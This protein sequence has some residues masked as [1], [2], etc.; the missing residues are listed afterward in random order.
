M[1]DGSLITAVLSL[2]S[3]FILFINNSCKRRWFITLHSQS[4]TAKVEVR[5]KSQDSLIWKLQ[6]RNV[7][8]WNWWSGEERRRRRRFGSHFTF[9]VSLWGEVWSFRGDQA[10]VQ[11][12]GGD[13]GGDGR[14]GGRGQQRHLCL[15]DI[16]R[17]LRLWLRL[18]LL[19][20]T[21]GPGVP[22]ESEGPVSVIWV[23]SAVLQ[24]PELR[25]PAAVS[26]PTWRGLQN[27]SD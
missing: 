15:T 14:D 11:F 7:I 16:K 18:S 21:P 5:W 6:K 4:I 17:R 27:V 19:S 10:V 22:V 3:F 9:S 25:R 8:L 2:I 1:V 20:V 12:W 24:S 26:L 13:G 23:P